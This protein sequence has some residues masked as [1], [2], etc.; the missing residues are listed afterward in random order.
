MSDVSLDTGLTRVL[1]R[2]CRPAMF[3]ALAAGSAVNGSATVTT[4][5]AMRNERSKVRLGVNGSLRMSIDFRLPNA[6]ATGYSNS[7]A[8]SCLPRADLSVSESA[9]VFVTALSASRLLGGGQV[10]PSTV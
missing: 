2:G 3:A 8:N 1:D 10:L 7:F 9:R 6:I 5:A 4:L